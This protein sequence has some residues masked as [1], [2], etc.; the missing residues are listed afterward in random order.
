M[1]GGNC[2]RRGH[3]AS[4]HV[5]P[6]TRRS[7]QLP[8]ASSE[9]PPQATG[10]P[11]R[12]HLSGVPALS[13]AIAREHHGFLTHADV[14]AERWFAPAFA[15]EHVTGHGDE[16]VVGRRPGSDDDLT[17]LRSLTR[18]SGQLYLLRP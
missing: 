1:L 14:H 9:L 2:S 7:T 3:S 10:A 16:R 18:L 11:D 15:P 5:I 13:C 4:R 12:L 17:P 6:D 8:S